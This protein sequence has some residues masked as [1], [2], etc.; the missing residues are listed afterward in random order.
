MDFSDTVE[1]AAFRREVITFLD[2]NA[3]RKTGRLGGGGAVDA[4]H[5]AKAKAWQATK[6]HAGFAG[7]T[8]PKAW[9]GRGGTPMQHVIYGQE[10][11]KYELP[12]GVFEIGLGMCIPTVA[13]YAAPETSQRH[14]GPALRGETIW[15]QLFSEPA[16]GSDVAGLRTPRR[17]RRRRLDHQRPEDLDPAARIFPILG[18]C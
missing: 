11:A 9:G 10:E 14:V 15:C 3:T 12:Q 8:W 6:A 7:I 13:S 5:V 1:E 16:A 4:A 18:C 2:E 17:T